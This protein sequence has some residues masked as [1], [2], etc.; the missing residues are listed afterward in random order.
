MRNTHLPW[1]TISEMDKWKIPILNLIC[2]GNP[3]N[4]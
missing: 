1:T 3:D 2:H 4:K